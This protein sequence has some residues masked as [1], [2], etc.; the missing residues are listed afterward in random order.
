MSKDRRIAEASSFRE[1]FREQWSALSSLLGER[2]PGLGAE[3]E[4]VV[5]AAIDDVVTK[6]DARIRAIGSY[7]KSLR[8]SVHA[9]LEH[10]EGLVASLPPAQQINQKSF[11]TAQN[12]NRFFVNPGEMQEIFSRSHEL[13]Q[14]FADRM[15]GDV[16]E[17]YCL[18]FMYKQEKSVLGM[19]VENNLLLRDLQRTSVNFSGHR[20]TASSRD[21]SE[22]RSSLKR[23]LFE[24]M[25]AYIRTELSG[26]VGLAKQ[27][28]QLSLDRLCK[29]IS[30]PRNLVSIQRNTLQV[31]KLGILLPE[32][33]ADPD[34]RIQLDEIKIA[35]L[36]REIILLA[37]YPKGEMLTLDDLQRRSESFLG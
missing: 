26:E 31:D 4:K 9:L 22:L 32:E 34:N 36:P 25:A 21:E 27:H 20:V 12:L 3:R 35:E 15:V 30:K 29:A 8:Q 17:A 19:G 33:M 1:L 18:L 2:D 23:L 13:Q 16:E 5:S 24:R 37:R 10:V 14:F 6:T 7:K 28:P 11:A